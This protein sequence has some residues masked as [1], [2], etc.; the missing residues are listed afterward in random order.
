ML[1]LWFCKLKLFL[2]S[3]NFLN[4]I[5]FCL[6]RFSVVWSH[7]YLKCWFLNS[8]SSN[9]VLV[10]MT[11]RQRSAAVPLPL[12]LFLKSEGVANRRD[13]GFIWS[14]YSPKLDFGKD[15][16]SVRSILSFIWLT[17][18][19]TLLTGLYN[20]SIKEEIDRFPIGVG[21]SLDDFILKLSY[22]WWFY[23]IEVLAPSR[24]KWYLLDAGPSGIFYSNKGFLLKLTG[25]YGPSSSSIT[26]V[27]PIIS[28]KLVSILSVLS[29]FLEDLLKL[30][31]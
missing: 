3:L 10:R 23:A 24:F 21:S 1:T 14:F 6:L 5:F 15:W 29:A 7:T 31:S 22:W 16:W 13:S 9:N 12:N 17:L 11:D 2:M 28:F 26:L 30:D 20:G 18:F 25:D 8:F 19:L 4:M 27:E